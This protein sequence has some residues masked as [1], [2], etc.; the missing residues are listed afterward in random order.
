MKWAMLQG[1]SLEV[2]FPD[3]SEAM[4]I[5]LK[6][7]LPRWYILDKRVIKEEVHGSQMSGNITGRNTKKDT[8]VVLY[9]ERGQ[10][11]KSGIIKNM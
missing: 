4:F 8:Y 7:L 1:E 5:H 3:I 11:E 6:Y 2:I 10:E 9:H